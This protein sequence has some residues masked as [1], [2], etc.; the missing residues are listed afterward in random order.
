MPVVRRSCLHS[1]KLAQAHTTW[2][3]AHI[4]M[5]HS[6]VQAGRC[7]RAAMHRAEISCWLGVQFVHGVSETRTKG[8]HGPRGPTLKRYGKSVVKVHTREGVE[9]R[10]FTISDFKRWLASATSSAGRKSRRSNPLCVPEHE[11]RNRV[12]ATQGQSHAE[13]TA[14]PEATGGYAAQEVIE[15]EHTSSVA[16]RKH[17]FTAATPTLTPARQSA[18]AQVVSAGRRT[19]VL[20]TLTRRSLRPAGQG[21]TLRV[22]A[23]AVSGMFA[24]EAAAAPESVEEVVALSCGQAQQCEAVADV[25]NANVHGTA[26]AAPVTV[27]FPHAGAAGEMAEVLMTGAAATASELP[28]AG[29]AVRTGECDAQHQVQ[30]V[31]SEVRMAAKVCNEANGGSKKS[32]DT[33]IEDLPHADEE[34]SEFWHDLMGMDNV[35]EVRFLCEVVDALLCLCS[36]QN[37]A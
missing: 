35:T 10:S 13:A 30:L 9:K 36:K 23:A 18:Q 11:A 37:S 26:G 1:I 5:F 28:A 12:S 20:L 27:T 4:E 7:F 29:T 24:V 22:A 21:D 31:A 15:G 8:W 3:H 6:A 19:G 25:P 16:A 14:L 17:T 33:S 32:A 34:G 2:C